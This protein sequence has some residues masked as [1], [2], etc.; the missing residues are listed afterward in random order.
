MSILGVDITTSQSFDNRVGASD[1]AQVAYNGTLINPGGLYNPAGIY[2]QS[3]LVVSGRNNYVQLSDP[4]Q[5]T[6]FADILSSTISEIVDK[7]NALVDGIAG[8]GNYT[9]TGQLANNKTKW[10]VGAAL[11]AALAWFY[12]RKR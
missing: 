9:T 4:N 10:I 2:N 8:S 12:F 6:K 7:T 1:N 3:G 11:L 5:G